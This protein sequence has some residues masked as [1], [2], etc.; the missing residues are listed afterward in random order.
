M[1]REPA[2]DGGPPNNWLSNFGGSAWEWDAA[3]KQFYYHSFLKQQPDLNWRNPQLQEAMLNVLRFWLDRGVD[4]FRVDVLWL[5]IKDDQFRDNPLNPGYQS[6]G[7]SSTRLLPVYNAD[8]PETH[9]LVAAMRSVLDEYPHR[10]FIGEIYFSV[11]QLV[12]YYGKDLRGA[13]ESVFQFS[14]DPLRLEHGIEIRS[15][16]VE[17]I[18]IR[19]AALKIV[20][21]MDASLSVPTAT[22]QR[23]IPVKLLDENRRII[24]RVSSGKRS[25]Q[26]FLHASDCLG[27]AARAGSVSTTQRW[28]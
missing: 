27:L 9:E 7:P 2:A 4:G 19:G 21:N 22:S 16:Q 24:N 13:G 14:A 6:N 10:V 25:R 28:F 15:K 26:G 3:T 1:W 17:V 20:E 11:K 12:N 23:R 18:P 8:R 5:L